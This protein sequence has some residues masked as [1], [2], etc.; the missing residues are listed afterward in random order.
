VFIIV[1]HRTSIYGRVVIHF[2]SD[3]VISAKSVIRP[4]P[5]KSSAVLGNRVHRGTYQPLLNRETA[6]CK[7]LDLAKGFRGQHQREAQ[8]GQ[9][10]SATLATGPG[11]GI[12]NDVWRM[13]LE[14]S[15]MLKTAAFGFGER[16]YASP[17]GALNDLE[18]GNS[19]ADHGNLHGRE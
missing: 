13:E 3:T 9:S 18:V 5:H 8:Y 6:K 17:D 4:D 19:L 1:N 15:S 7:M 14:S 2:K 10:P 16:G 11:I 12:A